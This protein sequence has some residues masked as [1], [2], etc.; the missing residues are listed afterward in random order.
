MQKIEL[1][2]RFKSIAIFSLII[3][4]ISKSSD[5]NPRFQKFVLIIAS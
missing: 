3:R 1:N 2:I 5:D 4:K